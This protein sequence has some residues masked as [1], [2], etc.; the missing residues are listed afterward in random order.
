MHKHLLTR[1]ILFTA[2]YRYSYRE[3][4]HTIGYN[5]SH[6]YIQENHYYNQ[7]MDTLLLS[8]FLKSLISPASLSILRQHCSLD[9]PTIVPGVYSFHHTLTYTWSGVSLLFMFCILFTYFVGGGEVYN[10]R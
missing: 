2:S 4:N 9:L 8:N 6:A 7:D 1:A 10:A 5:L 3:I